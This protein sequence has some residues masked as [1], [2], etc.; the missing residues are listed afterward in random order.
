MKFWFWSAANVVAVVISFLFFILLKN[1][2]ITF[3]CCNLVENSRQLYCCY[4]NDNRN[5]NTAEWEL[6]IWKGLRGVTIL[7]R[8]AP[9][10]LDRLYS[11]LLVVWYLI[12]YM[13]EEFFLQ[14][15][16]ANIQHIILTSKFFKLTSCAAYSMRARKSQS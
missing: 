4:N 1:P 3:M 12:V 13:H 14:A 15:Y 8:R 9:Y 7:S 5:C 2:A 11:I 6:C 16:W 10:E